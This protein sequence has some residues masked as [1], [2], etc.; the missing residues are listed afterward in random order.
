MHDFTLAFIGGTVLGVSAVG[1]L[2]I[3]GRIAG[4]SGI[5]AHLFNPQTLL[6]SPALYFLLG[7]VLVPFIYRFMFAPQIEL[8]STPWVMILAGLLVG[9]G[10]RMGS[11]CTSGHGIC[12]LSRLSG[13]SMVA[14]S[15][16]MFTGFVTV[17]I[18]RH[19]LGA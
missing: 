19:V 17:F 13:R 9:I 7:L 8:N 16:L 15:S 3:N 11:G 2:Y 10:A 12:G 18:I 4:I 6:K 1:Y 14:I 5:I